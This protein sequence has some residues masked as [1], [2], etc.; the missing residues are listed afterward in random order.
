MRRSRVVDE[1]GQPLAVVDRRAQRLGFA[2]IV[3]Q[4]GEFPPGA[5]EHVVER[6]PERIL[7]R[8]ERGALA[9][10]PGVVAGQPRRVEAVDRGDP[11]EPCLAPA[12]EVDLP[13]GALDEVPALMGPTVLQDHQARRADAPASLQAL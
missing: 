7:R 6:R 9:L 13:G 11:F 2:G 3:R 12:G 1:H 10:D 5:R 4:P 8:V